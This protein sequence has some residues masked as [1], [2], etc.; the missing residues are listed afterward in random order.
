MEPLIE[1]LGS[2]IAP[3]EGTSLSLGVHALSLPTVKRREYS[4]VREG[5]EKWAVAAA[6]RLPTPQPPKQVSSITGRPDGVPF[7]VT[8]QRV[9]LR[10]SRPIGYTRYAPGDP[11]TLRR[12]RVRK[13]LADKLPKLAGYKRV[14]AFTV[15]VLED[16]DIALSN[17]GVIAQAVHAELAASSIEPP[18]AIYLVETIIDP[19]TVIT[20]K[21]GAYRWPTAEATVAKYRQ[22]PFTALDDI[23]S[24]SGP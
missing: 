22:F 24:P 1:S 12:Q 13:A 7:D 20:L 10:L 2:Q 23:I 3:V 14:G 19:W 21:D 18:D 16:N 6:A 11:E 8:L 5:I 9:G 15:L 17:H 4:P